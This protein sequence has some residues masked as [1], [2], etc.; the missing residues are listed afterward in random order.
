MRYCQQNM[1]NLWKPHRPHWYRERVPYYAISWR[2]PTSWVPFWIYERRYD[3]HCEM[4]S[5]AFINIYLRNLLIATAI[6]IIRNLSI[7][8]NRRMGDDGK[9][10]LSYAGISSHKHWRVAL[11]K[12]PGYC[13]YSMGRKAVFIMAIMF[14]GPLIYQTTDIRHHIKFSPNGEIRDKMRLKHEHFL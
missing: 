9:S 13:S 6:M 5:C 11:M 8:W 1:I 12:R 4:A 2:L 3:Y 14:R 7:K 10:S